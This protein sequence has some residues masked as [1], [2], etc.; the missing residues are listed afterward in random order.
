[1][2]DFPI[3]NIIDKTRDLLI[4]RQI[5]FF[6]RLA[7]TMQTAQAYVKNDA[8][9][10]TVVLAQIQTVGRGRN[11]R[12]WY[13]PDGNMCLSVVLYPRLELLPWLSALGGL[14]VKNTLEHFGLNAVLKWPN[15]VLLN[16]KKVAGILVEGTVI[17][18]KAKIVCGIG[19]N[20]NLSPN[21]IKSIS[22]QAT[23]L[24]KQ[25]GRS[26]DVGEVITLFLYEMNK[27]YTKSDVDEIK[28]L[29]KT[30]MTC[31]GSTVSVC[32]PDG[33]NLVGTALDVDQN[34]FLVIESG[35]TLHSIS[36]G[37]VFLG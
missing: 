10:G 35:G 3:E 24:S 26:V 12:V 21:R 31:W 2:T 37:D 9:E 22:S 27:I 28:R 29:W 16:G 6:P 13:S 8:S 1:M 20:I 7:S 36:S 25:L 33:K 30:S 23:S 32:L 19:L 14:A 18:E 34:G 11:N 4:G 5:H 15:D 17:G